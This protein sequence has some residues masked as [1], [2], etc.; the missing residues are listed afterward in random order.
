MTMKKGILI[1]CCM[2]GVQV[3]FAQ[4]EAVRATSSGRFRF[5]VRTYGTCV[6]VDEAGRIIE[7]NVHGPRDYFDSFENPG[8]ADRPRQIGEVS[9]DYYD[10][11]DNSAKEGRVKRVQGIVFD[12]YDTF[13]NSAKQGK[14]KRIGDLTIDYYD[15][16]DNVAK[17]GKIKRIGSIDVDYYDTFDGHYREGKLR[18]IGDREFGYYANGRPEWFGRQNAFDTDGIR[19]RIWE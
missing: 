18:R 9:F 16:F 3:G 13:D 2:L 19:F 7:T 8:K 17:Q 6:T 5:V 14:V 12:Y 15:T 4:I 1:L 11:F 10:S